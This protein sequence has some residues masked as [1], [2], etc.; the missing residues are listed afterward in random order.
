[1]QIQQEQNR[2]SFP[3]GPANEPAYR[4]A[5][6]YASVFLTRLALA[7]WM[8]GGDVPHIF[9]SSRKLSARA[10]WCTQA[11][12]DFQSWLE[13]GGFHAADAHAEQK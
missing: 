2:S 7:R 6:E 12:Q 1:V 10:A 4:P 8:Q 5:A 13:A 11:Q 9:A 3:A